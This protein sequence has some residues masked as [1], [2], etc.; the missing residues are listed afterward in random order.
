MVVKRRQRWRSVEAALKHREGRRRVR[1][2]TMV[3]GGALPF[4]G[5]RGVEEVSGRSG[6]G[7]G[8]FAPFNGGCYRRGGDGAIE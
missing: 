8:N 4:I 6:G 3:D 2:G 5:A 7:G 1:R